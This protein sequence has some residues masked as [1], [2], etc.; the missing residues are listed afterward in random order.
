[1][2][3]FPYKSE[4]FIIFFYYDGIFPYQ[5]K[6]LNFF[7]IVMVFF[8]FIMKQKYIIKLGWYFFLVN[9][10]NDYTQGAAARVLMRAKPASAMTTASPISDIDYYG[11]DGVYHS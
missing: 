6:V 5:S 4:L 9:D 7:F 3:F 8:L 11:D 10:Y 1:M 2:L